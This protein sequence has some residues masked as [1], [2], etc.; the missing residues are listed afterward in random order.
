METPKPLEYV[1]LLTS[2]TG[3]D[4]PEDIAVYAQLDAKTISRIATMI[5][6]MDSYRGID[7]NAI[8]DVI[9]RNKDEVQIS[10][11]S[12]SDGDMCAL[13]RFPLDTGRDWDDIEVMEED[14]IDRT[15]MRPVFKGDTVYAV[16]GFY[17]TAESFF[18][19]VG[20]RLRGV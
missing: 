18:S 2:T 12:N 11:N 9:N 1:W 10:I 6:K 13:L 5:S 4:Y 7:K 20:R 14:E 15:Y 17:D 16:K 8:A 3:Y 19:T